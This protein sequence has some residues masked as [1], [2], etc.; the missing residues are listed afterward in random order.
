MASS[1]LVVLVPE[2]LGSSSPTSSPWSSSPLEP[3]PELPLLLPLPEVPP[4]WRADEPPR[5]PRSWSPS[6]SHLMR[7]EALT[8]AKQRRLQTLAAACAAEHPELPRSQRIDLSAIDLA[9]DG[10]LGEVRHLDSAVVV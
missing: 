4:S 7:V 2:E 1:S 3:E 5:W 9:A 10:S 6:D 8:V